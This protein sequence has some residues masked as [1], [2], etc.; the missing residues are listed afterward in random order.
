MVLSGEPVSWLP[1][2]ARPEGV[3]EAYGRFVS[4]ESRKEWSKTHLVNGK[5][6]R[7]S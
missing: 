2:A 5:Y 3:P 4:G 6:N 1:R 7:A